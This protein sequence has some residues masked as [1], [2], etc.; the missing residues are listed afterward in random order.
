VSAFPSRDDATPRLA[1]GCTSRPSRTTGRA[2]ALARLRV[3]QEDGELVAADAG[4]GVLGA[5]GGNQP[6]RHRDQKRVTGLVA[7]AVV[8]A[9]EVVEVDEKHAE[10]AA[11]PPV[12]HGALQTSDEEGSI[13][14]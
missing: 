9:L 13:G 1:L 8:D 10:C 7:E 3:L 2:S 12:R 11:T 5:H 14:Q 6:P 4:D